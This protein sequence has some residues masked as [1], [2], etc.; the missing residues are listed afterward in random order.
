MWEWK[1]VYTVIKER[2]D[3]M[4]ISIYQTHLSLSFTDIEVSVA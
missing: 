4:E 2:H 1:N 3:F